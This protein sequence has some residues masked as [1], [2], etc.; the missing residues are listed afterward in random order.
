MEIVK[1]KRILA[2]IGII[3]LLLGTIFPYMTFEIK[4]L[5]YYE[6]ISL[7]SYIEGILILIITFATTLIIFKDFVEKYASR[8]YERGLG[9]LLKK[10]E[11]PKFAI[12]PTVLVAGIAIYLTSVSMDIGSSFD[13]YSDYIKNG[14]GFYLLWLGVLCLIAHAFLYKGST[15]KTEEPVKNYHQIDET[16]SVQPQSTQQTYQQ[17]AQPQSMQQTYQQPVQPQSMQQTYQQP[18]QPQSMQ[19]TYQQPTQPQSM[20]QTYQQPT[21]PQSMQQ[22]YQQPTNQPNYK[23]CP[24]CGNRVSLEADTCFMCGNK[25]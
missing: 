2:L 20:Q 14:I 9:K 5:K 15:K 22:T 24:N 19:Q 8:L 7:I 1:N 6:S 23:Q 12:I 18:V 25:F 4:E 16:P 10:V 3:S 13:D 17:S 21:Q 11:N